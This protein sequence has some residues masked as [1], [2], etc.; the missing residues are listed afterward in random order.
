MK[1]AIPL[2]IL[3]LIL[4]FLG[5]IYFSL[6]EEDV[7]LTIVE[8]SDK[9][10][11]LRVKSGVGEVMFEISIDE[12]RDWAINNWDNIFDERPSFGEIREVDPNNFYVFDGNGSLSPKN[13]YLAF[14]VNDYAVLTN[15]SFIILVDIDSGELSM[16]K[17][18]NQ[19]GV[20]DIV[21]SEDENYIAY[22]LDTAR[23]GGDYLTVDNIVERK[24]E[25]IVSGEDVYDLQTSK[26]EEILPFFEIIGWDDDNLIF[27]TKLKEE[28]LS[29]NKKGGEINYK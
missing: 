11:M 16:I 3:L 15:I 13:N 7:N 21:W 14:S 18:Y 5:F 4:S 19:G 10:E 22:I 27:S 28:L 1:T 12:F 2:T 24:K 17:D 6:N 9:G 25:F 23:S 20:R 26:E 8:Y 29:I